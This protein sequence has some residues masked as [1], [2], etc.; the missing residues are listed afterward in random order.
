M[1]KPARV[2]VAYTTDDVSFVE[3]LV[4][5]LRAHH[6]NAWFGPSDVQGGDQFQ[7]EIQEALTAADCLILVLSESALKSR[8][9]LFEYL[10]FRMAHTPAR[11]I[12]ILLDGCNY[13]AFE[14]SV[15][16]YQA[17]DFSK[18][19]LAGFEKLMR[20]F[21]EQFLELANKPIPERRALERRSGPDRRASEISVRLRKGFWFS[22]YRATELEKAETLR[23]DLYCVEKTISALMP[24]CMK[25]LFVDR[26]TGRV[27][28]AEEAI[29]RV[30]FSTYRKAQ[31]SGAPS[32]TAIVAIE[33]VAERCL[34]M[35]EVST[36]DRRNAPRRIEG[37]LR[38]LLGGKSAANGC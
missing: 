33:A 37:D 13:L 2:F 23:M 25:Y 14:S 34:Q 20:S 1:S 27:C 19:A 30:V 16:G 21:G 11:I 31:A 35:F 17:I 8:W 32:P 36:L 12:P 7:D 9:M 22:F 18:S 5:I 6:V 15:G 24:E 38:P 28:P 29:E 10:V 4:T 26:L 3:L